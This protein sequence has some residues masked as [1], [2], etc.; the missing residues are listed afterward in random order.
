[1]IGGVV[2][3]IGGD[4]L[5]RAEAGGE[6]QTHEVGHRIFDQADSFRSLPSL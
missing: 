2:E 3:R 4:S 5:L 6:E 1:M